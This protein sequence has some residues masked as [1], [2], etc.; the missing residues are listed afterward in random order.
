VSLSS[1]W[2]LMFLFLTF[3]PTFQWLLY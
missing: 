2:K 1:L 3:I